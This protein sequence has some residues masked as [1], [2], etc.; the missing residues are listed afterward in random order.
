MYD[1]SGAENN[2]K[3]IIGFR[4]GEKD[5]IFSNSSPRVVDSDS[6]LN[7]SFSRLNTVP[8]LSKTGETSLAPNSIL[9]VCFSHL[10][11]VYL[12]PLF[13]ELIDYFYQ[14]ILGSFAARVQDAMIPIDPK[15]LEISSFHK[16]DI[17]L[18]HPLI[19]IPRH[20]RSMQYL[21]ADLGTLKITN[22][23]GENFGRRH[24][25]FLNMEGFS[26]KSGIL[27]N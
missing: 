9:E 20:Q 5:P 10:Q 19:V 11:I 17:I 26:L 1:I 2:F 18:Q 7:F 22:A 15:Y 4:G 24:Q 3:Q 16:I 12:Q 23:I 8:T 21:V 13:M 27:G 14:G 25:L 6:V